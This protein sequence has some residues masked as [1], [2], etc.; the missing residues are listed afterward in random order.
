VGSILASLLALCVLG[1]RPALAQTTTLTN[2]SDIAT[3]TGSVQLANAISLSFPTNPASTNTIVVMVAYT[4][5]ANAGTLAVSGLTATWTTG[6][7]PAFTS[8]LGI[9]FFYGTNHSGSQNAVVVTAAQPD[10]LVVVAQ[11]WQNLSVT[12]DPGTRVL[13]AGQN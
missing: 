13:N 12:E 8:G 3:T 5:A 2:A 4:N 9:A 1:V 6:Y 7:S 10:N 11:A